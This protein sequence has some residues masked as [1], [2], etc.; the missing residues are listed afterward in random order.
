M[1]KVALAVVVALGLVGYAV[2]Q[3][4][5]PE[6]T[7]SGVTLTKALNGA[8]VF[9]TSTTF[10]YDAGTA[11][12][13]VCAT[14]GFGFNAMAWCDGEAFISNKAV[15]LDGGVLGVNEMVPMTIRNPYPMGLLGNNSSQV[16]V[17]Y[18]AFQSDAG[19][20]VQCNFFRRY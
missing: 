10:H 7:K 9:V 15:A 11:Q 2:A 8:D 17:K 16:C 14:M 13:P 4:A 6:R 3:D 5:P 20:F 18:N 19:T 12:V 1:K